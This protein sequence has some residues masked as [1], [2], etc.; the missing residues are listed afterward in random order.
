M[1]SI[2]ILSKGYKDTSEVKKTVKNISSYILNKLN[3]D[4]SKIIS[5][6][7]CVEIVSGREVEHSEADNS[8]VVELTIKERIIINSC[9]FNDREELDRHI[10]RVKNFCDQAKNIES[11][12]YLPIN[13]R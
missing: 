2:K 12:T 6:N 13:M 10:S 9:D 3:F 7:S 11:L 1:F 5:S 8:V 4:N